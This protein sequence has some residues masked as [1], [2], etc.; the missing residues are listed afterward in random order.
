MENYIV[1][2]SDR[3]KHSAWTSKQEAIHQLNVLREHGYRKH[4]LR[5]EQIDHTYE[6]GHYFV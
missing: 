5:I 6:N 1:F 2:I 4:E 3:I